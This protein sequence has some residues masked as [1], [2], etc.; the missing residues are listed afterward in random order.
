MKKSIITLLILVLTI[1]SFSQSNCNCEQALNQLIER[2]ESDYPGFAEK[3][4]NELIYRSLKEGLKIKAQSI[5]EQDCLDL[6]KTYTKYFRDGHI[7][8]YKTSNEEVAQPEEKDIKTYAKAEISIEDFYKHIS[9]SSDEL[10]GV[11]KS[12]SYKVGLIKTDNEYQG[13]IIEAGNETW[14]ANEVKFSLMGDGKANYFM[15]DHSLRED[16]YELF[17]GCILSFNIIKSVFIK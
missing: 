7:T 16:N 13:F 2:V 15:G 10:E 5:Q 6:L 1:S 17:E 4:T 8:L 3:T 11:W 12:G 9:D 14:K